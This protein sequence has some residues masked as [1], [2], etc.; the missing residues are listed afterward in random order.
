MGKLRGLGKEEKEKL[1]NEFFANLPSDSFTPAEDR[2]RQA[3]Y[4][5]LTQKPRHLHHLSAAGS[6]E[7]IKGPRKEVLETTDCK[8]PLK[9]WIEQRIGGEI[10]VHKDDQANQYMLRLTAD[11]A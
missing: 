8:V 9:E 2:L 11:G 10:E 3:L 7:G 1:I 6:D 4:D 5:F